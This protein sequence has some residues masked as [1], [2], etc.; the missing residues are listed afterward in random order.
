MNILREVRRVQ[1]KSLATRIKL[2]LSFSVIFII[3]TYA[4]YASDKDIE[5]KGLEGDVTS[6]DVSYYVNED[7]NEILNQI[8]VF[9]IDEFYPGMPDREDVVHIYNVGTSSTSITYE[10]VSIKVFG[11]EVLSELRTAGEIQTTG[12]TTNL[13]SGET[14]YPFNI[15]YT[16]DKDYL[17]GKY[18]DDEATPNA[19][20]TFKFNVNWDYI[21]DGDADANLA[22]DMLDTQFGKQAYEYYGDESNDES[23]AVEIK[24]KITSNR[25][26]PSL[27]S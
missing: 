23:K 15:S 7:E 20:A 19:V 9:T 25:I 14:A 17:N 18:Q 1:E 27:E 3:T 16:Y 2:L 26:H 24:V 8:A 6:W 4:W 10:L 12:N 21:G 22:K 11:R 13:F 5:L